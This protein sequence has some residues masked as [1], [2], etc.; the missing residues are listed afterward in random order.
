MQFI[1]LIPSTSRLARRAWRVIKLAVWIRGI[2]SVL[3]IVLQPRITCGSFPTRTMRIQ[4][5]KRGNCTCPGPVFRS[6]H[7]RSMRKIASLLNINRPEPVT[8]PTTVYY[9]CFL[10][11]LRRNAKCDIHTACSLPLG[12]KALTFLAKQRFSPSLFPL[13]PAGCAGTSLAMSSSERQPLPSINHCIC[14]LCAKF[15]TSL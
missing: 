7:I 2:A 15:C 13:Q 14:L 5:G 1:R 10:Q 4:I 9:R 8:V 11:T 6:G 12:T 3:G